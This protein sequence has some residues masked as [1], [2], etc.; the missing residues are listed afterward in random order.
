MKIICFFT[1][2]SKHV[3]HDHNE[4]TRREISKSDARNPG[5]LAIFEYR[6]T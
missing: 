2:D 3:D 6:N 5:N 4:S 1:K